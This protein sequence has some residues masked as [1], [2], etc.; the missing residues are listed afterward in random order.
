MSFQVPCNPFEHIVTVYGKQWQSL[1][2]AWIAASNNKN[3]IVEN[4]T[5]I[6][7]THHIVRKEQIN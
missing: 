2:P 7:M 5:D 3:N 6:S 4:I 1:E